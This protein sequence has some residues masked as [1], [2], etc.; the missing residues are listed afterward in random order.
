MTGKLQAMIDQANQ[1]TQA[2]RGRQF[3]K[4]ASDAQLLDQLADMARGVVDAYSDH[5]AAGAGV[6]HEELRKA[7]AD[8][9]TVLVVVE[10]RSK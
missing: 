6:V 9:R 8:L 10:R 7:I 1:R 5:R 3:A 2:Q 4:K